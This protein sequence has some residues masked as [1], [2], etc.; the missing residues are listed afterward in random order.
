MT[1]TASA[2]APQM[3]LPSAFSPRA[4]ASASHCH[5]RRGSISTTSCVAAHPFALT[6]SAMSPDP[7]AIRAIVEQAEEM[8]VEPPRPLTRQMPPADAFRVAARGDVLEAP[9]RAIH[10]RVQA[11]LAICSQSVLAAAALVV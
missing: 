7:G 5:P 4:D 1:P 10:D 11:P 3:L 8:R 6:R 9:A 2:S